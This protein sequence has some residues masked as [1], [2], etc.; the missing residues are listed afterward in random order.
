M[1][2][3]FNIYSKIYDIKFNDAIYNV[4]DN[5]I[6]KGCGTVAL[7]FLIKTYYLLYCLYNFLINYHHLVSY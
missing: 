3:L 7:F 2:I 6:K 5:N 4:L 1:D